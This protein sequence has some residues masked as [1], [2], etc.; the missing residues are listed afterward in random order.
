M[1][2]VK[3]GG[4]EVTCR[5]EDQTGV[6]SR[7]TTSPCRVLSISHGKHMS[8]TILY[9]TVCVILHIISL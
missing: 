7:F 5:A 2:L 8:E 4:G 6:T 9:Y 1:G 3:L